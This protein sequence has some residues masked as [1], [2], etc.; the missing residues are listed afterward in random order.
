M[1]Y[2][3]ISYIIYAEIWEPRIYDA[4][5][6]INFDISQA[7]NTVFWGDAQLS[8][9]FWHVPTPSGTVQASP[10]ARFRTLSPRGF[11]IA[12]GAASPMR[13]KRKCIWRS[14]FGSDLKAES[15]SESES[16]QHIHPANPCK[17][18]EIMAPWF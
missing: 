13:R 18:L 6:Y 11:A 14:A 2:N 4:L 10:T 17:R 3:W 8:G 16:H 15:N 9:V 12:V 7:R 1:S 5:A